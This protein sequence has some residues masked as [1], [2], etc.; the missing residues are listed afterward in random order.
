MATDHGVYID[1]GPELP[2]TYG[3]NCLEALP[4]SPDRVLVL[5]ESSAPLPM[6]RER[7]ILFSSA[8]RGEES[9]VAAREPVGR[10]I[11]PAKPGS[12]YQ[13]LLGYREGGTFVALLRSS[14]VTTPRGIPASTY[15]PEWLPN[16]AERA[17]LERLCSS[18]FSAPPSSR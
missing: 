7:E 11:F 15:D 1:Y 9:A 13:A 4:L 8:E 3:G 6:G 14:V 10:F 5:W 2:A 17:F 16:D 18:R 12:V